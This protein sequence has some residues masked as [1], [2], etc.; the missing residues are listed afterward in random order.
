MNTIQSKLKII[1]LFMAV[2]LV[3]PAI[4][5]PNEDQTQSMSPKNLLQYSCENIMKLDEHDRLL[6]ITF[7]HGYNLGKK[8]TT[9]FNRAQL[10]DASYKF[11]D[12][13]KAHP[14]DKALS[15]IGRIVK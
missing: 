1:T 8:S 4:S 5:F 15:A 6:A 13:C 7:L 14:E 11:V 2:F 12:Y 10:S 9:K 3:I